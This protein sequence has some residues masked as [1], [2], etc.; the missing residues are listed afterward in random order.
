MF[1]RLREDIAAVRDRDPAARSG[2]EVFLCYPGIHALL[3]HRVAHHLWRAGFS[4]AARWVSHLAR[5]T[6]VS[7][8]ESKSFVKSALLSSGAVGIPAVRGL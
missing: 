2:L 1:E 7:G 3:L 8:L 4:T 6:G 5:G